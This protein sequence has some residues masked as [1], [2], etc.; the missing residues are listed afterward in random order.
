MK[1]TELLT[2]LAAGGAVAVV[3]WFAS[4]FLES[5]GAWQSQAREVKQGLILLGALVIGLVAV[6][7]AHLPA[8]VLEAARPYIEAG[9]AVCAAWLSSQ[10]AHK[11]NKPKA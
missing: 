4:W 3:S 10:V 11:L 9:I 2:W 1:M 5:L 7:V 6:W 8:E